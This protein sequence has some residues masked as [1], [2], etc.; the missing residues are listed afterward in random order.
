MGAD[1]ILAAVDLAHTNVVGCGDICHCTALGLCFCTIHHLL[2]SNGITS[3]YTP[4]ER[5]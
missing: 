3:F 5:G 4:L 1:T 2:L